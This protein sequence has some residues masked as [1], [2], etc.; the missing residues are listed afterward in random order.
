M[1]VH[2]RTGLA[3]RS[4]RDLAEAV[5][6]ELALEAGQLAARELGHDVRAEAVGVLD[7]ESMA[8]RQPLD[9][10]QAVP[11]AQNLQQLLGKHVVPA[12]RR[13]A[14]AETAAVAGREASG[15]VSPPHGGVAV[16][17][18]LPLGPLGAAGHVTLTG[19]R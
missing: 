6:V 15:G 8:V 4:F 3:V 14:A 10:S 2:E 13:R 1:E 11:V 12:A 9:H 5:E 17:R 16:R 19:H 18:T 7:G